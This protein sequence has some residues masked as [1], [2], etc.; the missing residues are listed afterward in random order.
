MPLSVSELEPATLEQV[1]QR[2]RPK[3]TEDRALYAAVTLLV[4]L[5]ALLHRVLLGSPVFPMD[6]AY[7]TL[8]NAQV[9][10]W[11]HDPN[12]LGT[13]ALAGATS[14]VHLALVAF[15]MFALSPPMALWT[16]LWL[17]TLAYALGLVRLARVHGATTPQA[18]LLACVGV[19]AGQVPHQLTN[20]LETGL[21]LAALTWA[22][23]LA[24]E[25]EPAAP[26]DAARRR[27]WLAA[28]CGLLPFI[29]PDLL[30]FSLGLLTFQTARR[31]RAAT[32]W[33][34]AVR[35]I[36]TDLGVACLSAAPWAL[37]YWLALGTPYPGTVEAKRF[38]FAQ[39]LL[40]AHV[41]V[42]LGAQGLALFVGDLGLLIFYG[43]LLGRTGLGR[44]LLLAAAVLIA[45]YIVRFPASL[46]G[47]EGRYLYPLLPLLLY[48]AA[49]A[50]GAG[51]TVRRAATVILVLCLLQSGWRAPG[52]WAQHQGYCG[53]TRYHLV[54]TAAWCNAHLPPGST[55]LVHDA[56]YI[57]YATRFPLVD[58]VGLKTPSCIAVHRAL[59][60]PSS[61]ALRGEAVSRIAEGSHADYL[62]V[63]EGWERIYGLA[64]GLRAQGWDV[65][66]INDQYAYHVYALHPPKAA[67]G[68]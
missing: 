2:Q 55:V 65:H 28:L 36:L 54:G 61:G 35:P 68:K 52:F 22:L 8:H 19:A 16:S 46:S 67:A 53:F 48:S 45:A 47:Y 20:G 32:S 1:H 51:P 9:L 42:S 49:A 62:I 30:V 50:F 38:F 31:V 10:H 6:D 60:H 57:A 66:L 3:G 15:L 14:A 44:I 33:R 12:Y 18:L 25:P 13:P 63:L 34:A 5:A 56:G 37:W 58:L 40:P 39:D 43:F 24:S 64:S 29:R 59:T 27:L 21:M 23:V 41:K 4:L 26:E 7:I 17:A 11:G